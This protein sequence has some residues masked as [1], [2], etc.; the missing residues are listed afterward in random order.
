[1]KEEYPIG[2]ECMIVDFEDDFNGMCNECYD[3]P[4]SD[5]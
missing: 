2:C 1:M 3:T 4:P 5:L